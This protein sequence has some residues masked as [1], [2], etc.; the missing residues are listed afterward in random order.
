MSQGKIILNIRAAAKLPDNTG[1]SSVTLPDGTTLV[2]GGALD[3]LG[4][5]HVL[6]C[7]QLPTCELGPDGQLHN[8][9]RIFLASD[10][11]QLPGQT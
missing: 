10:R 2:V 6:E 5:F 7:K 1:G 11:F 4:Q 3:T 8:Y 9:T